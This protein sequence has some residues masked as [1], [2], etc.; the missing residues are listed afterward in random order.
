MTSISRL[1]PVAEIIRKVKVKIIFRLEPVGDIVRKIKIIFRVE[2]VG[3][4]EKETA[5]CLTSLHSGEFNWQ[6]QYS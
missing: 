3:A 6:Y 1:G 2:P 5:E 4:M